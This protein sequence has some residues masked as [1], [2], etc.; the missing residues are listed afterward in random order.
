MRLLQS[1]YLGFDGN[2]FLYQNKILNLKYPVLTILVTWFSKHNLFSIVSPKSQAYLL[3]GITQPS[4]TTLAAISLLTLFATF[5]GLCTLLQFFW[6]GLLYYIIV[7]SHKKL[8]SLVKRV[9]MY[10]EQEKIPATN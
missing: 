6:G 9:E 2:S 8:Q 5:Y 10:L 1:C 7:I 3:N 4:N